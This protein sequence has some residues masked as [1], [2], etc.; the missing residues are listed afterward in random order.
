MSTILHQA[1]KT[2]ASPL[3]SRVL[4]AQPSATKAMT[5]LA[6]QMRQ[7]GLD[8]ITLSQGELD[9]E[10]PQHIRAAAKS[11]IDANQSGY[12]DVPG[13]LALRQAIVRKFKRD[14]GLDFDASQIQVGCGAKQVIYNALQA[15]INPGDEVIIAAPMW[16][17]YPEMVRLAQGVA[18]LVECEAVQNFKL[19]PA[20]LAR[21]ITPKTKWLMLNS[22]SNPTGAVYS[23]A[24]L[25]ALAQVL[26][27]HPHVWVISDDIYEKIRYDASEFATMAAVAPELVDRT[28]TVNGVSKAFAMTG[29][30]VGYGAGPSSLIQA[31]NL[32]QSQST[33]H[34]SSISQAAAIA[35]LD[36][37]MAFL[38]VFT[39]ALRR[40]RDTVIERINAIEGLECGIPQGAFYAFVDCK[41]LLGRRTLAG[42]QIVTDTDLSTY[43][44]Q[45]AHVAVVAGSAFALDG[46]LRLSFAT[47][48]RTLDSALERIA[49]ACAQLR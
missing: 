26:Q 5:A 46:Y 33:S 39:D 14:N 21:A 43:L 40:R 15:T 48:D 9:F 19:T 37:S 42:V 16:V 20:Q 28:L 38:D 25:A 12:T 45:T 30:R 36:G 49:T 6:R 3:A 13:T 4:S 17:S 27:A 22:P 32:I 18:V 41:A 35:A 8:V 29:W 2:S 1:D 7:Q 10:V 31:M 44:L 24:E 34:T 11:A 23:K 47:N